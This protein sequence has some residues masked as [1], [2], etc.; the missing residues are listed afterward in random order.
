[1]GRKS[2]LTEKQWARLGERYFNGEKARSLGPE[3]GV[4]EAA[5][6]QRFSSQHEKI[7]SV[8]NQ[9]IAAENAFKE[10]P[11]TSQIATQD[12]AAQLR[13]ISNHLASAAQY[14]AATAHRL[15]GIANG[16]VAEIDDATPLDEKSLGALK[17]IAVLTRMANES[18]EIGVNLLRANKET[19]DDLNRIQAPK[20]FPTV[21]HVVGVKA[22]TK[23][24]V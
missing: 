11:I 13:S 20:T 24:G 2:K 7:K 1:M 5:I 10:L 22:A 19:V 6:R 18:S 15:S 4:S 3:Y 14:G 9:I 23:N 17:G 12:L 21:I 8:A 16:K